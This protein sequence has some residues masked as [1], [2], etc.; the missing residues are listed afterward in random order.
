MITLVLVFRQ[1]I[2]NCSGVFQFVKLYVTRLQ[3]LYSF[4]FITKLRKPITT[5]TTTA[6]KRDRRANQQ[7][8]RGDKKNT[9]LSDNHR[10]PLSVEKMELAFCNVLQKCSQETH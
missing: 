10:E 6:K 3:S 2:E 8:S 4:L 1:A 5:T 9:H 7:V